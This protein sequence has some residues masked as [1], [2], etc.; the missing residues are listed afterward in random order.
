MTGRLFTVGAVAS[1]ALVAAVVASW[2]AGYGATDLW[3]VNRERTPAGGW[4]VAN[5]W[6]FHAAN[7][8]MTFV[9]SWD[10]VAVA[11]GRTPYPAGWTRTHQRFVEAGESAWWDRRFA[12][13]VGG[14]RLDPARE[15]H[16]YAAVTVPHWAAAA[17]AAVLPATW[18]ARRRPR[19]PGRCRRC[20][21]DLR[22]SP[23]R[24]PE[25]GAVTVAGRPI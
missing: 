4:Q 16:R 23:A 17:A 8:S 10:Q 5:G 1:A 2:V 12:T 13:H 25:C 11:S 7:G 9:K 22:A 21:Y 18:L 6:T 19:P 3:A 20:G 14:P 15:V 24:C